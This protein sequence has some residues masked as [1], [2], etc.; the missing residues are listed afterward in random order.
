MHKYIK[1]VHLNVCPKCK[2]PVLPHTVCQNCG[3][4]KGREVIDVLSKLSKK[5]KKQR[6]KEMKASASQKASLGRSPATGEAY[7]SPIKI[8]EKFEISL[9]DLREIEASTFRVWR[10]RIFNF[11]P[12]SV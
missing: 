2:K 3:T 11:K 12:N 4:Y 1:R 7:F 8:A 5:E 10:R 9:N 6:E